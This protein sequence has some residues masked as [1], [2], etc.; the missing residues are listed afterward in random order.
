MPHHTEF[1]RS[2]PNGISSPNAAEFGVKHLPTPV[3][4]LPS[5]HLALYSLYKLA[6]SAEGTA[7]TESVPDLQETPPAVPV[8]EVTDSRINLNFLLLSGLRINP[9]SK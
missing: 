7:V 9:S 8:T 1:G 4:P 6:S 3:C 5:L 2:F